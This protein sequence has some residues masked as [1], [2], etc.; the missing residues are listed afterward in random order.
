VQDGYEEG[1]RKHEALQGL[2]W[3]VLGDPGG[4]ALARRQYRRERPRN[5]RTD[6]DDLTGEREARHPA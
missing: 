2:D 4:R 3:P 5:E 6:E 1:G